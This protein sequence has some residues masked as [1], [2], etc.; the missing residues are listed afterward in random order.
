MPEDNDMLASQERDIAEVFPLL[1]EELRKLA[2]SRLAGEYRNQTLQPTALVHE[3]YLRLATGGSSRW[4]SRSYFFGAAAE[5]MRRILIERIRAK[6]A[7]RRGAGALAVD[8]DEIDLASPVP[9]ENLLALDGI[10]EKLAA[11][12]PR[13]AELVKL[14]FFAGLTNEELAAILGVSEATLKR[15][16][17]FTRA[18]LARELLRS[19][20]EAA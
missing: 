16:W 3:V 2:R 14:K 18:W 19:R 11:V 12:D 7:V 20:N 17:A 4:K 9:D 1:Y 15:T 13:K 10:I 8:L 6:Q 5:A